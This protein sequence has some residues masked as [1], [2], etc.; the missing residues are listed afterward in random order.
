[1]LETDCEK[2]I[3]DAC[4]K[5]DLR[6]IK[7]FCKQHTEII[8]KTWDNEKYFTILDYAVILGNNSIVKELLK[9][10]INP[11]CINEEGKTALVY[12]LGIHKFEEVIPFFNEDSQII[13]KLLEYGANPNIL[14]NGKNLLCWLLISEKPQSS[15]LLFQKFKLIYEKSN[16]N[17][18]EEDDAGLTPLDYAFCTEK[19]NIIHFLMIE[20]KAIV[21]KE[22]YFQRNTEDEK[23]LITPGQIFR[24][25]IFY[26]NTKNYEKKMECI[27]YLK[28][29][30]IDYYNQPM[31]VFTKT[32]LDIEIQKGKFK[33]YND[34]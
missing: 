31:D 6:T 25:F 14:Y 3:A 30:G 32:V 20:K 7:K 10:G 33:D 23:Q 13:S 4:D 29:L 11:N 18:N 19:F 24:K 9:L 15:D 34:Y 12:A 17:I 27:N 22:F 16:I 28:S 2:Q 5:N 1:M 21:K 8:Q 26:K